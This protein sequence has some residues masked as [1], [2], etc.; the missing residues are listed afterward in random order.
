MKRVLSLRHVSPATVIA[1]I[2]LFASL[3][4]TGVAS[5][6]VKAVADAIQTKSIDSGQIK[7]RGIKH[8]NIGRNAVHGDN[9]CRKCITGREV[10]E[11]TLGTVPSSFESDHSKAADNANNANN[12]NEA[13]H[14]GDSS[15]L[16]G[17]TPDAYVLSDY[18]R[19]IPLTKVAFGQN[20][21]ILVNGPFKVTAYCADNF[22]PANAGGPSPAT[23]NDAPPAGS[24]VGWAV[25]KNTGADNS[26]ASVNT[27]DNEFFSNPPDDADA[28]KFMT[29]G[30]LL[31]ADAPLLGTSTDD[32]TRVDSA[33]AVAPDGTSLSIENFA[34]GVNVAAYTGCVFWGEARTAPAGLG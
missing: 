9:I 1:T 32:L 29:G 4:G 3:V 17:K 16:G 2:A 15:K 20:K 27:P 34:V 22:D 26:I 10:K 18:I 7:N 28:H 14:S 23:G 13:T 25:L 12:A 33:Y 31:L 6:G 19:R 11:R 8:V 21:D 5:D 30:S 24:T